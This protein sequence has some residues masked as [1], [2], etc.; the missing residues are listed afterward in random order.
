VLERQ[1][2]NLNQHLRLYMDGTLVELPNI[3]NY[4]TYTNKTQWRTEI[5]KKSVTISIQ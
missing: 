4:F 5:H 3:G 2:Q 1:C